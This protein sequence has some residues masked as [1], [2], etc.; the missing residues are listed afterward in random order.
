MSE[1]EWTSASEHKSLVDCFYPLLIPSPSSLLPSL[2]PA[3]QLRAVHRFS[4]VEI[5]ENTQTDSL[6]QNIA[7]RGKSVRISDTYGVHARFYTLDSMSKV[8]D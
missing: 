7:R 3:H 1:L 4:F 5:E 2:A 8:C 6:L